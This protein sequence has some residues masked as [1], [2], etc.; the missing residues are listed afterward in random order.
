MKLF[1][2]W[3]IATVIWLFI[4]IPVYL[5]GYF[6]TWIGLL[7]CHRDS[8]F[9]PKLWWLWDNC[10][11]INGTID[12]N[13][14]KWPY[15][16]NKKQIDDLAAKTGQ[17]IWE[18]TK[19]VVDRHTGKERTYG[20]RWV[21]VTFRNPVSNLSRVVLGRTMQPE[22]PIRTKEWAF[23]N[24]TIRRDEAG[25]LRWQYDINFFWSKTKRFQFYF[26]WKI[27]DLGA[28]GGNI[29]V[30]MYRISPFRSI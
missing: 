1:Y 20:K 22:T 30:F 16:C 29:A 10:Y 27:T 8:E 15:T 18:V 17:S 23:L 25:W 19:Q 24:L 21:W 6:V 26:G 11:G 28:G 12:Y 5:L 13:N 4:W 7:F 9:M 2:R 3:L 14:L